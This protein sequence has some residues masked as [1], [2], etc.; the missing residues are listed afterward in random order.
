[1][2]SDLSPQ[3]ALDEAERAIA[4]LWTDYPPTPWWYFPALGAWAGAMVLALTGLWDRPV[5]FAPLLVVLVALEGAFI[6]WIQQERGTWPRLRGAP[7]EFQPAIKGYFV[8]VALLLATIV[9]TYFALGPVVAATVTVLW[10]TFGLLV[11]HRCYEAA[12]R[13]T[14]ERLG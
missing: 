2:E 11:Y 13:A 14:R 5:V 12:A 7:A 10:V 6:W 3:G 4:V 8:G 1:M 9:A